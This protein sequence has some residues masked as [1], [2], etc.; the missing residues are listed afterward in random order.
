M[1]STRPISCGPVGS[2]A[3]QVETYVAQQRLKIKAGERKELEA[4]LKFRRAMF[5]IIRQTPNDDQAQAIVLNMLRQRYPTLDPAAAR[6][7]AQQLTA[8]WHRYYLK[9]DPQ[10][11]LA[12]VQCPVLL[13]NGTGDPEVNAAANLGALEKGL[14]GNKRVTVRRLTG[15]NHWFQTPAG[16]LLGTATAPADPAVSPAFLDAVRDWVLLTTAK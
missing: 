4:M 1:C 9:F 14:R 13:L 8:P 16:E 15:L 11:S 10:A 7:R 2:N 5:E 3:A 6:T 12:D